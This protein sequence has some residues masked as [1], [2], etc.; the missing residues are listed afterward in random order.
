MRNQLSKAGKQQQQRSEEKS[1]VKFN[2]KVVSPADS[3]K[4]ARSTAVSDAP[5]NEK[6]QVVDSA[7]LVSVLGKVASYQEKVCQYL[8]YLREIINNP[9]ELEDINDLN[10]RQRR[11]YEFTNR[12][13]RNHLYQIGRMVSCKENVVMLNTLK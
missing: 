11:A 2:G 4:C 3:R 5:A 7:K 6:S 12:F 10:K 9:P 13:A 1:S 8:D